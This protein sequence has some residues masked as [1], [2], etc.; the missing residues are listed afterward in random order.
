MKRYNLISENEEE[1]N[2]E[3][4]EGPIEP[5]RMRNL[6]RA[7]NDLVSE[8]KKLSV[9]IMS[10]NNHVLKLDGTKMIKEFVRPLSLA[11]SKVPKEQ[12]ER[13]NKNVRD[14]YNTMQDM[15]RLNKLSHIPVQMTPLQ[16][17][18]SRKQS[19]STVYN[20]EGIVKPG[21]RLMNAVD[22]EKKIAEWRNRPKDITP[23]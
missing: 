17:A 4:K 10:Q 9:Q 6:E 15:I 8:I 2:Y 1:Q 16:E 12:R 23:V 5:V 18:L 19:P 13:R 20:F 11:I 3:M 14:S 22:M 21:F 7:E